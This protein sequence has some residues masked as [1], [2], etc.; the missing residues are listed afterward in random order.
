[1]EMVMIV[2]VTFS[3]SAAGNHGLCDDRIGAGLIQ[4]HRIKGREHTHVWY[5]SRVI[6]RMAVA[7]RRHVDDQGN[8]EM[9]T[10][11]SMVEHS[12]AL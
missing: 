7:I 5:D 6:F 9:G 2:R 4:R 3:R 12:Q 11:D 8:M 10:M 1:M